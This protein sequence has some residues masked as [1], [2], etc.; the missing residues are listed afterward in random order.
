MIIE[1]VN[2]A[3]FRGFQN[4]QFKM[5]EQITIIAGQ[6]GTQKTTLL[7][8]LSQTFSLRNHP[9]ET[10]RTE[11]PL[12]GGNFISSFSEKFKF[13][14]VYDKVGEH[15]WSLKMKGES[16]PFV[17]ASMLRDKTSKKLRFW[18]KGDREGGS[19]YLQYPV[20]FLS[21][22][23]LYP[24]GEDNKIGT[25]SKVQLAPEEKELYQKLHNKILISR[26]KISQTDYLE[27][28]YK[29]TLG[30]NT[31]YYDW[32]TNS[33]GQDNVSKIILAILSFQR[34][35]NKYP[36]IYKGGM[37][38]ID[39]LDATMY[40]GSQYRLLDVLKTYAAR[41]SVQ[42]IFTTHSLS[43]L[44]HAFEV[45][46]ILSEKEQTI[47]QIRV[48]YLKK[49][50]HNV[51]IN[52][53]P[54]LDEIRYNLNVAVGKTKSPKIDLYTEDDETWKVFKAFRKQRGK[55]NYIKIPFSCTSLVGLVYNKVPAFSSPNAIIV[56]DGDVRNNKVQMKQL[57]G[58][59]NVVLLPTKHSPERCI[60]KML[61]ELSDADS[62][63]K[64]INTN[65]SKQFAFKDIEIDEIEN[66]REAAKRWFRLQVNELG[67]SWVTKV[68]NRWIKD[69]TRE[70]SDFLSN[71]QEAYNHIAE[72]LNL[73]PI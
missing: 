26:D 67:E 68:I 7:G 6:N 38:V 35:K 33:A 46:A 20:I 55:L 24:L 62:L 13:S 70:Y 66:K 48:L 8:M 19:G 29:N 73:Q 71:Y 17:I 1:E 18:K 39:E 22:K 43:L 40:P 2:I 69:H 58:K 59:K 14:E 49:Q 41:L 47:N 31:D 52:D 4:Q 57:K 63:W 9:N 23:R 36:N 50:D 21:L 3:R 45:K 65:Y 27:S 12:C 44:K 34:L 53:T 28:P 37:L 5:G 61:D 72:L 16:E 15:E 42:V 56:L 11:K 51:I 60:A 64:E 54:T 30:A 10:F 32:K 25:S